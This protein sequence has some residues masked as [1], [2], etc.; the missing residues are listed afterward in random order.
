LPHWVQV[1]SEAVVHCS[2]VQLSIGAQDVQVM[3]D[4]AVQAPVWNCPAPQ[5]VEHAWQVPLLTK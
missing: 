5:A 2:A 3:S 4:V 1:A